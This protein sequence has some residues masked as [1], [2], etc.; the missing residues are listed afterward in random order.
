M[1]LPVFTSLRGYEPAWLSRDLVAGLTVW[2]VL[3]PES[4]AYA[5]IAGVSP[6]VGLYAAP[7]ALIFYA[8][9]GS[10]RHLIVGPMSATAALSAATIA[11]LVTNDPDRF[12]ELTATLAITVGMVA[13]VAGILRFGFIANFISEPVLKGFI[14]GLAL[15]I[16]VG[17]LPKLFGIEGGEGDFFEKLWDVVKNLGDTQWRTLTVGLISLA[18][19][20]VL[21]EVAP[22]IPAS[23][24][25]VLFGII[26]VNL[27]DLGDKGSR[28]WATS[29][30]ASR[31]SAFR[32]TC[33]AP[34]TSR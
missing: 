19:V 28:S 33:R 30:R 1:R 6:V 9:F 32:R 3:V 16:L 11:D 21:R 5:S 31:A 34:T 15:T 26:V 17:Q 29:T 18:I 14:I 23:L 27:F 8:A 24:V 25:A 4:L 20:L 12:T 2:A 22:R 10:S 13:L 7:A